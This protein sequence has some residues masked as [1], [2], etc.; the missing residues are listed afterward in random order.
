MARDER[1]VI[2]VFDS[3]FVSVFLPDRRL[4][5]A[6]VI[7]TAYSLWKSVKVFAIVVKEW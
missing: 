6:G 5:I 4:S 1:Y 7:K 3:K 2:I